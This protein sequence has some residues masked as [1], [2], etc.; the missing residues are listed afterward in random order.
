MTKE[1][2]S[3]LPAQLRS[4]ATDMLRCA[5]L[6]PHRV[7]PVAGLLLAS[8]ETIRELRERLAS[9][10]T[11]IV[12][13]HAPEGDDGDEAPAPA[14]ATAT[15]CRHEWDPSA[16]V[17]TRPKCGK[18]GAERRHAVTAPASAAVTP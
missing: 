16:A 5:S 15:K 11:A 13:R 8:A 10:E 7:I 6:P 9:A 1:E 12:N 18:C 17:G 2:H 14:A 4:E 3:L